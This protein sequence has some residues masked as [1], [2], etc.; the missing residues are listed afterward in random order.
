MKK[1]IYSMAATAALALAAPVALAEDVTMD[2]LPGPVRDT[3]QRELGQGQL[4][5]IERDHEQGRVVYE[6]EL[7]DNGRKF[8]LDIAEDGRLLQRHPD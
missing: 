7:I 4:G 1:W 5:D 6:V 2:Q 3:V 8:E